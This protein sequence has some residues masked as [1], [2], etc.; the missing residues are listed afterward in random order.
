MKPA[1]ICLFG[2]F[3]DPLLAQSTMCDRLDELVNEH[4]P[5]NF[6]DVSFENTTIAEVEDDKEYQKIDYPFLGADYVYFTDKDELNK[7]LL[8]YPLVSKDRDQ[9]LNTYIGLIESL[10]GCELVYTSVRQQPSTSIGM[11]AFHTLGIDRR[12]FNSNIRLFQYES[13]SV[14]RFWI[15]YEIIAP[16]EK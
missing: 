13:D 1:L 6:E 15:E 5:E 10:G 8:C 4:I 14:S 3:T 9:A 11:I 7:K 12:F 2:V 16:K